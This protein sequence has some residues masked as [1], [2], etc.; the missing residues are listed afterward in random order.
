[1]K[2]SKNVFTKLIQFT[3]LA[4]CV[5]F[6]QSC[7][8]EI[9]PEDLTPPEFLFRVTGD[10]FNHDFTQ[11]SDFDDITLRLRKGVTYSYVF[12]AGDADGLSSASWYIK[13]RSKTRVERP[14]PSPWMFIPYHYADHSVRWEGDPTNP[15]TGAIIAG[16]FEVNEENSHTLFS[17]IVADFGGESES[18]NIIREILNIEISDGPTDILRQ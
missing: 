11:D 5:V 9:P 3:I 15:L 2:T 16:Y 6:T 17:F 13:D 4:L 14:L 1:M 12:S 10:G 7:D 18:Q 8:T